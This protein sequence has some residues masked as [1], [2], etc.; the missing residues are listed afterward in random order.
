MARGFYWQPILHEFTKMFPETIVFTGF[1]P[2]PVS[3][4]KGSLKVKVVGRTRFIDIAKATTSYNRKIIL[5]S[6][7]IL[8]HLLEFKP[9]IIFANGF[10]LWTVFSIALKPWKKWRVVVLYEGSSPGV[11]FRKSRARLAVRRVMTQAAD[12]F[13]TNSNSGKSYLV[14]VLKAQIRQVFVRPY[15]VPCVRTLFASEKYVEP[16]FSDMQR[17]VFLFVGQIIPRKGLHL[18]FKAC[19]IL[20]MQR[21]QYTLLVVGDGEQ[22]AEL[23]GLMKSHGSEKR[24]K[25]VN[26]V[27]YGQLGT[28]FQAADIFV[29]PTLE[30]TWGMAALEAMAFG[31][32]ILCSKYAGAV[33]LVRHGEN[34]FIF[35]PR[36][37]DKLAELMVTLIG[38]P[39]LVVKFG[40][41]SKEIMKSYTPGNAVVTF[42]EVIEHVAANPN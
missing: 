37:P 22:R 25:W 5:P 2:G 4:C 15:E 36:D 1:W 8:R 7:G 30:D 27:N 10:T 24:V 31:K 17:P 19:R 28:Y 40:R 42:R 12:A 9:H 14:E 39:D 16:S 11:D 18:L 6:L 3:S 21:C 13:I 29:F 20:Q 41:K 38:S 35:D 32:P 33:E 26:W 34:G 23:E